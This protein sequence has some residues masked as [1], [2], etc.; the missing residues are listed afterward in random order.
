MYYANC[1]QFKTEV[2]ELTSGTQPPLAWF[3]I[4]L[5][6]VDD[7]D[8]SAAEALREMIELLKERGIRLTCVEVQATVRAEL[9]RYGLTQLIGSECIFGR[10]HEVEAAY[11]QATTNHAPPER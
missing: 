7:V 6:A 8:F 9:D 4:D 3:C 5:G 1:N 2:R 10:I 11:L